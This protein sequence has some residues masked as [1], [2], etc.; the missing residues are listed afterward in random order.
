M[1]TYKVG[2]YYGEQRASHCWIISANN[3]D[4]A[5]QKAQAH[6]D[7]QGCMHMYVK[8]LGE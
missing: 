3:E 1:K 7:A 2:Y 6:I 8:E 5:I 4:E